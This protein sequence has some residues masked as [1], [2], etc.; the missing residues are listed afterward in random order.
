M[1]PAAVLT[2]TNSS[3]V[4]STAVASTYSAPVTVLR[5]KEAEYYKPDTPYTKA[6]TFLYSVMPGNYPATMRAV[7][8]KRANWTEVRAVYSFYGFRCNK[9][10]H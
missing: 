7:M 9:K 8:Q 1:K 6:D 10:T 2:Q 4:Q 3:G 5:E